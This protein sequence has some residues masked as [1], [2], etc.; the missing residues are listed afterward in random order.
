[1][2]LPKPRRRQATSRLGPEETLTLGAL[3]EGD[4]GYQYRLAE[5]GEEEGEPA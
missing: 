4:G 2:A 5:E 1:M 3:M